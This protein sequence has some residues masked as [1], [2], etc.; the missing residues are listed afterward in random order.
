MKISMHVLMRASYGYQ[1]S[2]ESSSDE[3]WPNH[4][5]SFRN[6]VNTILNSLLIILLTPKTLWRLPIKNLRIADEGYREF[7]AYMHDFIQKEKQME[8]NNQA[9]NLLS[10]L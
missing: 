1:F 4:I 7:G 8:K 9:Q 5:L 6:A 2:W 3:I 10:V